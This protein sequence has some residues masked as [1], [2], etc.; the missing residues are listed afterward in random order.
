MTAT[1]SL[2]SVARPERLLEAAGRL[3]SSVTELSTQIGV[4]RAAVAALSASWEGNAATAALNRAEW[5][6]DRQQKF[7][8]RLEAMASGLRSGGANLA[9]LRG[10]ILSVAT[11]AASLGGIVSDDGTVRPLGVNPLM[12]PALAAAYTFNIKG[13]STSSMPS[14][15]STAQAIDNP[16]AE[17]PSPDQQAVRV[18]R[19]R[20]LPGRSFVGAIST[21]TGS[22]TVTCWPP[23][24]R[25]RTPTRSH[26]Q[27]DQLPPRHRR[28]R[29]HS[30]G[31]PAMA[32][33]PGDSGRYR[34]QHRR[35]WRQ[36]CRHR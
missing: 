4:Q 1:L 8:A 24:G 25:S 14:T 34:R 13:C 15:R 12:T 17:R 27:Q 32:T 29:C 21:R 36:W 26:Q 16:W 5:D 6:L 2:V 31:R 3:T 22:A 18:D 11:Q 19:R 9:I 35:S 30:V 10:E 20:S 33:H 23:W 28:V 7:Q